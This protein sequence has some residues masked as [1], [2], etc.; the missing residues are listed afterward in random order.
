MMITEC[1][2]KLATLWSVT[3]RYP[4]IMAKTSGI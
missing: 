4:V 1:Q 2:S 3:V